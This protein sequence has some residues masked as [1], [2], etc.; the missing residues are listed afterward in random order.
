MPLVEP[1]Q[2]WQLQQNTKNVR[3]ISLFAHVDHGK[4]SVADHL[5]ASNGVF[6]SKMASKMRYLDFRPDEVSRGITM[7]SSGISL[8]YNAPPEHYLINL[9]D[10]PGH[11]DFIQ[12]TF[13]TSYLTDGA[14]F[15]VDVVEGLTLSAR[16]M[17]FRL[18]DHKIPII[19]LLNKMDR[20][21]IERKLTPIEAYDVLITLISDINTAVG[22]WHKVNVSIAS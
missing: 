15:L 8:I 18:L 19:L 13:L 7:K 20:L 21:L 22:T 3:N 14:I 16:G 1:L 12:E 9:C 17:L 10:N 2:L 5:I 11:L 6:H 4:S